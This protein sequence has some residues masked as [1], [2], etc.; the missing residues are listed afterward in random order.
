[1]SKKKF[2]QSAGAQEIRQKAQRQ[3]Q[4]QAQNSLVPMR[5][6]ILVKPEWKALYPTPSAAEF[7]ALRRQLAQ[8]GFEE[9]LLLWQTRVR[10]VY[11]LVEGYAQYEAFLDIDQKE[12]FAHELR[13]EVKDFED[14]NAVKR[15]IIQRLL[16]QFELNEAQATY[17]KGKMGLVPRN[18]FEARYLLF[19]D[20][21]DRLSSIEPNLREKIF[22]GKWQRTT[23][24]VI[25]LAALLP[26]KIGI[27]RKKILQ[28]ATSAAEATR[29]L[30][31]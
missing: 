10:E 29:L 20:A 25:R 28:R 22:S 7:A 30:E 16:S 18:R 4:H 1:M 3:T 11:I 9:P 26:E 31:F 21:V 8:K 5:P 23:Y 15:F 19:A 17:L 13:F 12:G 2:Q 6:I 24:E 27:K 14:E